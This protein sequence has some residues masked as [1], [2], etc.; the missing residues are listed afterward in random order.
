MV[1]LRESIMNRKVEVIKKVAHQIRDLH[2]SPCA[3]DRLMNAIRADLVSTDESETAAFGLTIQEGSLSVID[4]L[5]SG[6][7]HL[8]KILSGQRNQGNHRVVLKTQAI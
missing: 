2:E 1:R 4:A 3:P 8:V 6:G 7:R 5:G